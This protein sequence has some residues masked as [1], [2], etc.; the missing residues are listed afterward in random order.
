[1]GGGTARV[2]FKYPAEVE[3]AVKIQILG[4]NGQRPVRTGEHGPCRFHSQ[5]CKVLH[6]GGFH[7]LLKKPDKVGF[8]QSQPVGY[9]LQVQFR[10]NIVLHNFQGFF[11][12]GVSAVGKMEFL[13][14]GEHI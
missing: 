13:L 3:F 8:I 2:L 4:N 7:F 10:G 12:M 1:M 11:N 6:G 14:A 9:L 5:A